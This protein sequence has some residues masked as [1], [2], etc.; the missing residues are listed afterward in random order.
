MANEVQT[1]NVI[2]FGKLPSALQA[3]VQQGQKLNQDLA[4]GITSGFAVISVRGKVFRIKH[5]GEERAV[6]NQDGSAAGILDVVIVKPSPHISKIFYIDGY[7]EGSNSPP[8][9][10]SVNGVKPDPASPKMQSPTCAGCPQNAWGSASRGGRVSKGKACHDSKRLAVVPPGNI[11]NDMYNGPML[12]R[13]PADSL[14]ELVKYAEKLNAMGYPVEAV[15]TRISFD[16][17]TPHP[18]LQFKE[19]RALT[20]EEYAEVEAH[21]KG[22]AVDRILNTSVDHVQTDGDP[23]RLPHTPPAKPVQQPQQPP[24]GFAPTAPQAPVPDTVTP[25]QASEKRIAEVEEKA[26]E[27]IDPNAAKRADMRSLGLTEEQIEALLGPEPKPEPP[28]DPRI[29]K[30]KEMGFDDE[31]I[32]KVISAPVTPKVNGVAPPAEPAQ[33]AKRRGRRSNAEIEA[34][35]AAQKAAEQPTEN[36]FAPQEEQPL[37]GEVLPPEGQDGEKEGDLPVDFENKLDAILGMK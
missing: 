11:K 19:V 12:I 9:C 20:D 30:L 6:T 16:I 3:R 21:L 10:W 5:Q 28:I 31:A 27:P 4:A 14:G 23:A 35:K 29:A 17:S 26:A 1:N 13:V 8:D 37:N 22:E 34:E 2:P 25:A 24:A 18:K 7:E 33:P 15:V 32:A 36:A